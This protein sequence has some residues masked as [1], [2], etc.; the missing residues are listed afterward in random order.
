LKIA[1]VTTTQPKY[2]EQCRNS[3]AN[4]ADFDQVLVLLAKS[5]KIPPE[6]RH[7]KNY[8][9]I[10][11]LLWFQEDRLCIPHN[12]TLCYQL[13]HDHHDAIGHFGIDK[14]Y[15]SMQRHTYWSRMYND[16]EEYIKS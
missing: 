10:N 9:L 6:L 15:L 14:T 2:V 11:G 1:N 3:H 8:T 12:D 16:V 4:N 5:T 13:L 7:M